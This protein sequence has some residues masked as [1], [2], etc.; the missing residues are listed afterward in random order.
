MHLKKYTIASFL[1][2]I[3]V[4]WYVYAFVTQGSMSIDIFGLVLPPLS[5]AALV[6]LPMVLLYVASVLH[7]S[8]YSL[9]GVLKLRKYEKDHEKMV[10]SIIDAYLGKENRFHSFKTQKYKLL[11]SLVDNA[12]IF[13]TAEFNA[14]VD[15]KK[16]NDVLNIISSI[17]NGEVADLRKYSLP[18]SNAIVIQNER[19]RY[20]KGIL[21]AEDILSSPNRYDTSLCKE[22]YVDFVK[23]AP[24]QTIEK[25]K[26]ALTKEALFAIL[27]RINANSDTLVVSNEVLV[28]LFKSMKL[29]R[30][31]YIDAS[32]TLAKAMLP[33]QRIKL[34]E[35]LGNDDEAAV[36]AY[37][38]TL[39]DLE[40]LT[41]AKEFL[42]ASASDEYA[43][44]RAYSAL[45]A[46]GKYFDINLFI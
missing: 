1:L 11:G 3:L 12:T 42:D 18:S 16:I 2:I 23:K 10:D 36:E 6:V 22:V 13:P 9:M 15:N 39:F 27:S 34:F 4:G 38:F 33:E 45:R 20:K 19:N 26:N 14:E 30:N 25:Y 41:P 35:I 44:F 31:E 37:L 32:K 17:R 5:I 28:S 29:N 8:F 43:R 24:L 21:S 7:M 40:M 46:S